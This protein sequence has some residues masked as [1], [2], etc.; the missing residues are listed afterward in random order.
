MQRWPS[1]KAMNK[2]RTRVHELTSARRSG[3]K[4]VKELITELTPIL[5]GWGNYFRTGNADRRFN[6]MDRYVR[7]RLCRWMVR[8]GG[9]RSQ[10]QL[11]HL[12][13]RHFYDMGLYE[14]KGTVRYPTQATSRQITGKP[15]AGNL[16]VR[17]ERGVQATGVVATTGA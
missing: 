9:Q 5:R 6:Q 12:E 14:L 2:L 13:D 3:V 16:H 4:D 8:R 11:K 7:E 10:R 15:Y 17:F 1:P